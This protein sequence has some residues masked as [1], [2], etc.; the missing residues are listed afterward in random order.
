MHRPAH[1]AY[2]CPT[3]GERW[4]RED[5]QY[6]GDALA[7]AREHVRSCDPNSEARYDPELEQDAGE[8]SA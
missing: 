7:D 5:Y 3:C 2:Y 1:G 4:A 6:P 8:G